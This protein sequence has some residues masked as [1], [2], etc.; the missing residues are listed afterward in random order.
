MS[1]CPRTTRQSQT[2]SSHSP[3]SS[4][5]PAPRVLT[6]LDWPSDAHT[7]HSLHVTPSTAAV[8]TQHACVSRLRHAGPCACTCD[9]YLLLCDL[10]PPLDRPVSRQRKEASGRYM[11]DGERV[12][13]S[14]QE[15]VPRGPSTRRGL[16]R[17]TNLTRDLTRSPRQTTWLAAPQCGHAT[18]V[19]PAGTPKILLHWK[20]AIRRTYIWK[21]GDG[22]MHLVLGRTSSCTGSTRSGA[23]LA[24]ASPEPPA[25]T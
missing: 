17:L 13:C 3:L 7:V 12:V 21:G 15:I 4:H 1:S 22:C 20:H 6:D 9:M 10:V 19:A 16:P 25:C 23:P 18:A 11:A 8:S 24:A 2:S 14:L 5:T